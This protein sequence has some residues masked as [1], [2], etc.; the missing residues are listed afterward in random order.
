M[1][2]YKTAI[3][4]SFWAKARSMQPRLQRLAILYGGLFLIMSVVLTWLSPGLVIGAKG[5]VGGDFLAFYTAGDMT[6]QGRA[7]EAYEFAA[8]DAALRT[9]VDHEHLGMMWQYPPL[10]FFIAAGLAL[11]PYKVSLWLWLSVTAGAFVW[12]LSRILAFAA[13]AGETQRLALL[14][15]MTSPLA[16]MVVTSGQISFFTAALLITAGFRPGRHWL[17]A[18]VA[19]G[20][21]T[22]KP[23]L[24]VLIPLAFLAA[25][26]WRA[27]AVAAVTTVLLHT[28][29]ILV[30]GPETIAAFFNAV[31]RL[32]SDVAGSGTHTPPVNMTTLF[33]QLKFW[34]MP[35]DAAMGLHLLLAAGVIVSVTWLWR[36][37]R[38][39]AEQG[40]YLTALIGAGAVLV[41]P[42]A[43]AYEMAALAPAAIWLALRAQRYAELSFGLLAGAWLLLTVR[44]FVPLDLV[45]Q[46]P[47]LISLGAFLLLIR[48]ANETPEPRVAIS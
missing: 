1:G 5:V 30:F 46:V 19:A 39:D 23:Q 42:Y 38:R 25:G 9:R 24:G 35:S 34:H 22:L 48:A 6:L 18:G 21:L 47:F 43:Y 27:F 7:L 31:V 2:R 45:V 33:G 16:L 8:F 10:M 4:P 11:L 15:V 28:I 41:T 13:P 26:A 14:L 29:S 3:A 12:A 20:L 37:H 32:Q 17:V 44:A 40:L 36:R